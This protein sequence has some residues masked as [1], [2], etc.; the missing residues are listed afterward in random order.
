[1]TE[2]TNQQRADRARFAL[3]AYTTNLPPAQAVL[4]EPDLACLIDLI[5]DSMH[6]FGHEAVEGAFNL[7]TI[8]HHAETDDQRGDG[9]HCQREAL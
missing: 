6:L 4:E 5:A 9:D 7:A 1:M 3:T 2:P 8:H